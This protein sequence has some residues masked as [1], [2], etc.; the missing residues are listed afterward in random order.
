MNAMDLYAELRGVLAELDAAGVE[1]ALCGGLA[2]A[3]WGAPRATKDIDLLVRPETVQAAMQAVAK[4]KFVLAA[5]PITFRDGMRMQR[6][7]R[8]EAGQLLTIDFILADENLQRA[9][10]SRTKLNTTEGT[11]WVISREALIEMKVAAGRP[12]DAA[13]IEKLQEMD[14]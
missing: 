2:V 7:S 13:D 12:I 1:Y 11:T 10:Q 14:R 3:V 9:W 8:V 6:V 4:R 5:A